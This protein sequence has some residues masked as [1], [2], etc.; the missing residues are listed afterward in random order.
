M[1]SKRVPDCVRSSPQAGP[2]FAGVLRR[3]DSDPRGRKPISCWDVRRLMY[4]RCWDEIRDTIKFAITF[5]NAIMGY[6]LQ[7]SISPATCAIA[8]AVCQCLPWAASSMYLA[9]PA[10]VPCSPRRR[11]CPSA[12]HAPAP[13][14][15]Q[16]VGVL[17]HFDVLELQGMCVARTCTWAAVSIFIVMASPSSTSAAYL[18]RAA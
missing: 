9:T 11:P 17:L 7:A 12:S 8:A 18:C 6:R 14:L 1:F 5:E 13:S 3:R 4:F 2:D 16:D 10:T 15:R